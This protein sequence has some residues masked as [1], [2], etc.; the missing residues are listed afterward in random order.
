MTTLTELQIQDWLSDQS[1]IRG[2]L[3]EIT[4][5]DKDSLPITRYLSTFSYTTSPT[6]TPANTMYEA[7]IQN[8]VKFVERLNIKGGASMS[9]SDIELSNT[10]G[11]Y[12]DWLEDIWVNA[13]AKAYIGD[14]RWSRDKFIKIFDG[15]VNDITTRNS[16]VLNIKLMDKLQ[17]LNSPVSEL[18]YS[19]IYPYPNA[20]NL[21]TAYDP[22]DTL[23]LAQDIV[24][25][26]CFGEVHNIT[27]VLIDEANLVYCVHYGSISGII[28][29]RDN[30]MPL[31]YGTSYTVQESLGT[32]TMLYQPFGTLTVSL[33]GDNASGYNNTVASIIRR[34]VTGYGKVLPNPVTGQPTTRSGTTIPGSSPPIGYPIITPSEERFLEGVD[35]DTENFDAFELAN[36]QPVGI[37]IGSKENI[38]SVLQQLASSVG[39]SLHLSRDG[40]LKLL[41][42]ASPPLGTPTIISEDLY[43]YKSLQ[44]SDRT[45][46]AGAIKLAY[47]KNWTV[48]QELLTGIPAEHKR[49]FSE[50][51]SYVTKLDSPTITDRKLTSFPTQEN[52]LLIVQGD[53]ITEAQRRLN[54]NKVQ[55]TTYKLSGMTELFTL[56]LG[57][58]VQLI[59]KRFGLDGSTGVGV[60]TVVELQTNW[61]NGTVQVEVFI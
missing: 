34:I 29:V 12:D 22:N 15:V 30:G 27:P 45:E 17:R 2:T 6:S 35:I 9:V 42:L 58:T 40:K 24:M 8:S 5:L 3:V 23:S 21:R 51:W 11:E 41:T 49:L 48:Q 39:A 25:P 31:D 36:P 44:I 10:D 53:A 13:T 46:V 57:D 38:M 59:S 52:T 32:I 37:Y 14:P 20:S 16:N 33:Q 18:S 7:N 47:N 1:A 61:L 4:L 55:H 54:F 19:D 28:E 60:G 56:Q 26:L 43:K 50:Q